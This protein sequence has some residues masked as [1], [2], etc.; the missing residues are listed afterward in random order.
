MSS[1][2]VW[3]AAKEVR[4]GA[5][6][7]TRVRALGGGDRPATEKQ[8]GLGSALEELISPATRGDPMSPLRWTSKSTYKLAAELTA[9]GFSVSAEL[10]RRLLHQLGYSLQA[11]SKQR[12]GAQH[13]D[14][15]GQFRYVAARTAEFATADEPVI[16][17]D[18]KKKE[19]VGDFTNGGKEWQP[20]GQPEEVRVHDFEDKL[21]GKAVPYGV[22]DLFNN[23]GW[24]S[25]G[26][27]ADTAEFA[28]SAIRAW[29][30]EMGRARFPNA[31]RL[32]ISADAG[33]SNGHRVRAWKYHLSQLADDT[34]LEITVCHFPPGTSKWNQIEH[35]MFSYISM[36][37]RGRA[38]ES[39]RTIVELISAT[40]TR[41]GLTIHARHD[42]NVYE[43]GVKVTDEQMTAINLERH[44]WHGD[45]N[46]T[47]K[48]SK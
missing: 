27:N 11:L 4:E 40:T 24:V 9:M 34:G 14:R 22:Y 39:I 16:S 18:T 41:T 26:D 12:E 6:V 2:T 42:P 37:W 38:L 1:H 31:G 5:E 25:V 17:V 10:V 33:G 21:L 15:D 19:L 7:T 48:P 30:A 36:N 29:W 32:L 45:W 3:R 8:P 44:E 13:E 23:E 28:V 47:I 20:Q 35:R 46:Y 43:R